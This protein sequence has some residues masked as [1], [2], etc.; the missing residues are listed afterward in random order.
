MLRCLARG[1]A[2]AAGL[3]G[4]SAAS[5][6]QALQ[7]QIRNFPEDPATDEARW[8]LG[9]LTWASGDRDKAVALWSEIRPGSPRWLE[10]R[11]ALADSRRSALE[12]A[13]PTAE[14]HE[15]ASSYQKSMDA[16]AQSLKLA[17]AESDEI[18]LSL[19]EARLALTPVVG[20]PQLALSVTDRLG[21]MSLSPSQRYRNRLYVTIAQA[22]LGRYVDAEREAQTHRSWMDPSS[23]N[24]FLDAVRVLDLSAQTADMDLPQRRYGMVMRLLIQ[25][26]I[27]DAE[28]ETWTVEERTVLKL[29]VARALLFLG[30]ERG[31]Q[32]A[33]RGWTGLPP[34]AGDELLRDLADT[35]SRLEAYELAIDVQRLRAR[36]LPSGSPLWFDARYGLALAYFH[37]GQQKEAAQLIDATSILHP[38]LGGGTLKKK[39]IRLRQRLGARP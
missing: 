30:G 34:S 14:R 21:R 10:S 39:L 16:L 19:A 24:A 25:P 12:S 26:L 23:R 31:A 33:L 32:A 11:L 4:A 15:L 13:L 36:N 8:L 9:S 2:L 28:D 22:Q 27:Q 3:P 29:R 38:D 20:K 6:G 7:T 18:E 35:Y 17:K 1:R 37:A 5:Y